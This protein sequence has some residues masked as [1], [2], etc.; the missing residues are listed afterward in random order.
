MHRR[1][2]ERGDREHKHSPI[3]SYA[4]VTRAAYTYMP[5]MKA[6]RKV[7][8]GMCISAALAMPVVISPDN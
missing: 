6:M 1:F 5:A 7:F 4:I 3:I 8:P 2:R